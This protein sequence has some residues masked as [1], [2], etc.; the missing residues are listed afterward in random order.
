MVNFNYS[1][2][3][4]IG[5]YESSI[6][7]VISLYGF[8]A[9]FVPVD[10]VGLDWVFNDYNH[11]KS[12][13]EDVIDIK[14]LP[15]DTTD[16][17]SNGYN[18]SEF[19]F[20]N[21]TTIDLI[22][23][24]NTLKMFKDWR[25]VGSLL[26]LPNNKRLEITSLDMYVNGI[27]NLFVFNNDKSAYRL[28]CVTYSE[29]LHSEI[30]V[31]GSKSVDT[32]K[33]NFLSLDYLTTIGDFSKSDEWNENYQDGLKIYDGLQVSEEKTEK[34]RELIRHDNPYYS[35]DAQS[36]KYLNNV[37]NW[38]NINAGIP[39]DGDFDDS[40]VE[41]YMNLPEETKNELL[42]TNFLRDFENGTLIEDED[43]ELGEHDFMEEDIQE[44]NNDLV[45]EDITG[46]IPDEDL[47]DYI[48]VTPV[49]NVPPKDIF[50]DI[51]EK[52]KVANKNT[53]ETVYNFTDIGNKNKSKQIN[54]FDEFK[55]TQD[56]LA[57]DNKVVTTVRDSGEKNTTKV[58][59]AFI[60][61][62]EK[63]IWGEFS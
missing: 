47:D 5:T 15:M 21:N 10:M 24:K 8:N 41:K 4:T 46:L 12:N 60:D 48:D 44:P 9:K 42:A 25:V 30:N 55:Q 61:K 13:A 18:L 14:V 45:Y 2:G 54:K 56:A 19:G 7:E 38:H 40:K 36:S 29:Q 1:N 3:N 39:S 35:T 63:S 37:A 57:T 26:V 49:V 52:Y 27:N 22:I 16:Y 43:L 33:K 34:F 59:K 50:G 17:T 53:F 62:T 31:E 11:L 28:S 20:L 51:L 32:V 6:D 58:D 23:S